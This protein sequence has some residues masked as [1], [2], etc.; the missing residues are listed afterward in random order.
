MGKEIFRYT[1]N[2]SVAT[3]CRFLKCTVIDS[4]CSNSFSK[5]GDLSPYI[6]HKNLSCRRLIIIIV[7]YNM[8][9]K[10]PNKV[11]VTI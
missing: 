11:A 8:T 10:H 9:V 7:I 5:D 1:L 6:R 4:S 3:I 2:N